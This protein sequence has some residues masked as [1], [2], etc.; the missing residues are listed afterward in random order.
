MRFGR[1]ILRNVNRDRFL[2]RKLQDQG[3]ESEESVE[4]I[5]LQLLFEARVL[6]DWNVTDDLVDV[7]LYIKAKLDWAG[8]IPVIILIQLLQAVLRARLNY[9]KKPALPHVHHD[10]CAAATRADKLVK[11]IGGVDHLMEELESKRTSSTMGQKVF[12]LCLF[13]LT[14]NCTQL[15]SS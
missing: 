15:S 9:H 4:Y 5:I 2:F 11:W 13:L 12:F 7:F 14:Q 1:T 3:I 6:T 10:H 8:D